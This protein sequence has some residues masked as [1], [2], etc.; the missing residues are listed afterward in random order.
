MDFYQI[1]LT[2]SYSFTGIVLGILSIII[3]SK[4]SR[5]PLNITFSIYSLTIAWWNISS[6]FMIN[7][8]SENVATIWGKIILIGLVFVPSTFLHFTFTFLKESSKKKSFIKISYLI[9]IVFFIFI[10]TTYFIKGTAPTYKLDYFTVSGPVYLAFLVYFTAIVIYGLSILYNALKN[11]K[12]GLYRQQLLY[13]FWA[14]F[15]GYLGGSLNYNLVFKFPPYEMVPWGNSLVGVYGLLIAYAIVKYRLLDIKVAITR[16]GIFVFV[17]SLILG[18]P[19]Y[20]GYI[21]GA[22][23]FAFW[24]M[25]LL[26]TAGPFIFLS[27]QRRAEN[28]LL[29][30]EREAYRLLTQASFGMNKKKRSSKGHNFNSKPCF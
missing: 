5:N 14:T 11:S 29:K 21:L 22:W 2:I 16:A 30:K 8:D 20:I 6:I 3:L 12:A 25:A 10:F 17:Y 1:N 28:T 27:L 15:F 19:I 26:A 18:V 13:L 9:S 24:A 23:K 4:N 7:A